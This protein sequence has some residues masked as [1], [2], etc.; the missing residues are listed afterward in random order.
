MTDKQQPAEELDEISFEDA[1]AQLEETVHQLEEGELGLGDSL[2]RYQQCVA[3]LKRCHQQL[4]QATRQ[5][6]LLR[7]V[8]DQGEAVT[9][10][11]EDEDL[12]LDEKQESRARRRGAAA[13][14][15]S[16]ADTSS[17]ESEADDVD[18]EPG[19]F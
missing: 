12:S 19:L 13:G 9:A 7:D 3:L 8:D 16:S 5:V 1:L 18:D 2:E 15:T 6:E 10:P 4:E 11:F 14:D 17:E